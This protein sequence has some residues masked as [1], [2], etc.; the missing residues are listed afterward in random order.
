MSIKQRNNSK[1]KVHSS[2]LIKLANGEEEESALLPIYYTLRNFASINAGAASLVHEAKID[3]IRS[4]WS[5]PVAHDTGW[6]VW[7]C[8]IHLM[9]AWCQCGCA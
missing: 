3:V 9:A 5:D 1:I 7:T 6:A 8:S 2:R 4:S